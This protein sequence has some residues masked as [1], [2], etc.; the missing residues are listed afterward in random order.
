[1]GTST[2]I[3]G[4]NIIDGFTEGEIVM[5]SKEDMGKMKE[6]CFLVIE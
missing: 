1:V 4:K 3:H 5:L 2:K 6:F